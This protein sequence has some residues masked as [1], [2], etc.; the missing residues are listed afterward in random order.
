ML[1]RIDTIKAI[2]IFFLV[3]GLGLVFFH[4][5]P[6]DWPFNKLIENFY[7]N[8]SAEFISIS[9]TILLINYLYEVKEKRSLKIRLIREL[10]SE[11]KGLTARAVKEL[12][13]NNWLSDGS[14]KGANLI[15]ANL[16]KL[17]LSG[18]DLTEV[19][20]EFA[21]ISNANLKKVTLKN[22]KLKNAKLLN[23][24]LSE[25]NLEGSILHSTSFYKS[26]LSRS[27][28][29]NADLIGSNFE[30]AE[31]MDCTFE[32][33]K[34]EDSNLKLA[35]LARSKFKECNLMR[36][37]IHSADL[38]DATLERCNIHS[39]QNWKDMVNCTEETFLAPINPPQG[40]IENFKNNETHD[41]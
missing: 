19:N 39:L 8:F 23:S 20:L 40:F 27:N 2:G 5:Y 33:S 15:N 1:K 13:E 34:L 35:S 30:L 17:D 14:L 7:A 36:V 3:T 38:K 12:R 18:A 28:F 32:N 41:A 29:T 11:E 4:K 26:V 6:S 24:D 25:A 9:L 31:L 16:S 21:D 37:D 22:A 10:G